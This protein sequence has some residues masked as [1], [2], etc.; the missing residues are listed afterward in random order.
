MV[1]SLPVLM[2]NKRSSPARDPRSC[3]MEYMYQ[4][5]RRQTTYRVAITA[6]CNGTDLYGS[7]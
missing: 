6:L 5:Y 1:T 4:Q 2:G 7:D 3:V